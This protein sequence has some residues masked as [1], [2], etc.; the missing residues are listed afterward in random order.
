ML[1][2]ATIIVVVISGLVILGL[3]IN[4]KLSLFLEKQ[5]PSNDLI[6]WLKSTNQR[7]EGQNKVFTQTLQQHGEALNKR[8]DNAARVI[9]QVQRNIGEM[10]EIGRGMKELQEF[11]QSPKLRGNIGEQVLKDLI[12]QMFPK[13]SF[14]LQH[15][16]KSGEKV[17]A[18][19]KTS[20]GIL[21][22][23]SKFPME[24]FQKM[25]KAK[26]SKDKTSY[27]KLFI[28]DIKKHLDD[29]SRKYILPEEGTMDF[30][31]MYI[32]SESVYYEVVNESDLMRLAQRYRVYPVSPTTLY[33]H[34]QT[35]LLSF[36]GQKIEKR[37]REVF[38]VLRAIQKD[39]SKV[40]DNLGTLQRH[41]NN[42][43]N[44][45]ANVLTSFTHLGQK[46]TST[47][48]LGENLPAGRQSVRKS[49]KDDKM[50][51]E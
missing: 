18:A 38:T 4:K 27:K 6:E 17:D 15:T 10:S 33:A 45:M 51:L 7:L 12:S 36:E 1:D 13:G 2:L 42:A 16:F 9:S 44:M 39:Y 21:P 40:E 23:D 22:I 19:I 35:I 5:K 31:L 41:L 11:L 43:Y 29:I 48:E 3:F 34:L 46:I 20:A 50:L 26:D 37:A 32:P 25:I 24:N 14:Y 8:L 28:R 30:A 49:A 47:R